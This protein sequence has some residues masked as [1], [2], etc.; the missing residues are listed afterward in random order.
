MDTCQS[1]DLVSIQVAILPV[2]EANQHDLALDFFFLQSRRRAF[3][4]PEVINQAADDKEIQSAYWPCQ[5]RMRY[6]AL[7]GGSQRLKSR[8]R[9]P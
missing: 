6:A 5:F 2:V 8:G 7:L 3:L 1:S 4:M 9:I